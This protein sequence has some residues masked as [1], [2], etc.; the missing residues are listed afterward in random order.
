MYSNNMKNISEKCHPLQC[1]MYV[2]VCVS[3]PH[4]YTLLN[5]SPSKYPPVCPHD[6][7]AFDQAVVRSI[8]SRCDG[9]CFEKTNRYV[10]RADG[11]GFLKEQ[12]GWQVRDKT[13]AAAAEVVVVTYSAWFSC[14]LAL[15]SK[16]PRERDFPNSAISIYIFDDDTY[17]CIWSLH[18]FGM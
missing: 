7:T 4:V 15:P 6:L 11:T 12:H 16:S 17:C 14:C 2:C 3:P 1:S 18:V 13:V 10:L 8:S 9:G 5:M